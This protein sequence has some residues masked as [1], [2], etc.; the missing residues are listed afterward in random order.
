MDYLGHIQRPAK[1]LALGLGI[2]KRHGAN[3]VGGLILGI[4]VLMLFSQY[5]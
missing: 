2:M 4:G 5:F 1:S 3:I